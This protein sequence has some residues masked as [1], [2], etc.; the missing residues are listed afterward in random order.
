MVNTNKKQYAASSDRRLYRSGLFNV[1]LQLVFTFVQSQKV[2][3]HTVHSLHS[4]NNQE[5]KTCVMA[6]HS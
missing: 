4:L 1:L 3:A 2:G 6:H 5:S